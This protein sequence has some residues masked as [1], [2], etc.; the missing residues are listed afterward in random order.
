MI[1]SSGKMILYKRL[2]SG[3]NLIKLLLKKHSNALIRILMGILIKQ[4]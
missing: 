3:F 2:D 4:T 1:I